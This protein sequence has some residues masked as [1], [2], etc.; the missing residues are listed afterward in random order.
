MSVDDVR[1]AKNH[2]N[3]C[4]VLIT[5]ME[6]PVETTIEALRVKKSSGKGKNWYELLKESDSA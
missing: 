5:Q 4:K 6:I 2:I 3:E 1:A